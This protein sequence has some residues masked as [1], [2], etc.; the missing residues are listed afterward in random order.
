M[1]KSLFFPVKVSLD[2]Y[3]TEEEIYQMSLQREPRKPAVSR[4][5]SRT[6]YFY[7]ST[8]GAASSCLFTQ[9]ATDT[10]CSHPGIAVSLLQHSAHIGNLYFL[11]TFWPLKV[12]R[13]L[14]KIIASASPLQSYRCL[15]VWLSL[16][17]HSR[18]LAP[19][20][21]LTPSPPWS[22]TGPCQWSPAPT[23]PSSKST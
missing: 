5:L 15:L 10:H 19:P 17:L 11:T 21:R 2:Q 7:S 16:L 22:M 4:K 18:T 3:H 20:L 13:F 9:N 1:T 8:F 6:S 14:C 12:S 23:P